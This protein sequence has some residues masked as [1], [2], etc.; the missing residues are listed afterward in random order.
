[1]PLNPLK[2]VHAPMF[3]SSVQFARW[4]A[5]QSGATTLKHI[6]EDATDSLPAPT[7]Q[8]QS[9]NRNLRKTA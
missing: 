1:M 8:S 9:S 5:Q 3:Q 7:S 4:A 2:G 6:S